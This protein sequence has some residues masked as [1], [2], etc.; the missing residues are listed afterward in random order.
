MQYVVNDERP[1]F[2][3]IVRDITERKQNE[4][5]LRHLATHDAL[6]GLPNRS[7]FLERLTQEIQSAESEHSCFGVLLLD[8][9]NFKVVND[10][11]GHHQGDYLLNELAQRLSRSLRA[12]DTVARLGGDEYAAILVNVHEE[13]Q[14]RLAAERMLQ[15]VS[16]PVLI[17]GQEFTPSASIGYRMYWRM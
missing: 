3:A 6:T 4:E 12:G 16:E 13:E 1:H 9:D 5:R 7:L 17:N 15:V 2:V 14:L 11:F 8:L 10:S